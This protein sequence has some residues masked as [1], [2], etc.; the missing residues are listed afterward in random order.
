L[1]FFNGLQLLAFP[2]RLGP[3]KLNGYTP[4]FDAHAQHGLKLR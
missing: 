1:R 3:A 2:F 4:I